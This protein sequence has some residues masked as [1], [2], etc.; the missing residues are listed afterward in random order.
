MED[1]YASS[2]CVKWK[3]CMPVLMVSEIEGVTFDCVK[4]KV[5]M[6]VLMVS[7]MEDVTSDCVKWKVHVY[8]SS[9]GV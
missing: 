1:V 9:D 6:P 8:A 2:D 3:V 5:C 7:E 4:W